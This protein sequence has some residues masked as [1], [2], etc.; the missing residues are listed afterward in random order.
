M[1]AR[2]P[3][4]SPARSIKVRPFEGGCPTSGKDAC[5]YSV[6]RQRTG[7]G[8]AWQSVRVLEIANGT[9]AKEVRALR[10]ATHL[11]KDTVMI[12]HRLRAQACVYSHI[13]K[14]ASEESVA[15]YKTKRNT[16]PPDSRVGTPHLTRMAR[17]G[18][19]G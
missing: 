6:F 3:P 12:V 2:R 16:Q 1:R 18:G 8:R 7:I 10:V 11:L 14:R 19:R 17:A 13:R 9:K 5:P 4:S 15:R